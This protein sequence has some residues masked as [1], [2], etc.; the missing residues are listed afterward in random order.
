M[1][2]LRYKKAAAKQLWKM[3]SKPRQRMAG[4]L[5]AIAEDPQRTDLDAKPLTGRPGYRLRVGRWR[6]IYQIEEDKVVVLVL[7][8]GPRGD[9]YK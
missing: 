3:P 9:I 5:Q 2:T 7:D 8:I 6:A 4:A 1:Y